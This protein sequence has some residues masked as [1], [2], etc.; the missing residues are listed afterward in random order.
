MQITVP[1]HA[2][3]FQLRISDA[4]I[5][6]DYA[7]NLLEG[8]TANAG[9]AAECADQASSAMR[10]ATHQV[11]F[12]SALDMARRAASS[13]GA[14]RDLL[15]GDVDDHDV[16]EATRLVLD[17]INQAQYASDIAD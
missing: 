14:A 3:P 7:L 17:G 13:F 12:D 11:A 1:D 5:A 8:G 15:H 6:G 2:S 10:A 9:F 4:G 16:Q